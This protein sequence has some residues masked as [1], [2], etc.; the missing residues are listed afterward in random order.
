VSG[1]RKLLAALL[2]LTILAASAAGITWHKKN[3]CIVDHKVYPRNEAVL[4]LRSEEISVAHYEKLR[5]ELPKCEI[6]WNIPFQGGIYSPET[7]KLQ[8]TDISGEELE[9]LRYFPNLKTIDARGCDDLAVIGRLRGALPET[10]LLYSVEVGGREYDQSAETVFVN[11]ITE[12]EIDSLAYLPQ[13]RQ[14]HITGGEDPQQLK[15]LV[16]FCR[17]KDVSVQVKLGGR[18]YEDT[19]RNLAISNITPE[20]MVLLHC[21]P[22]LETVSLTEPQAEAQ[23]LFALIDA[24]PEVKISWKK[25]VLGTLY[26]GD[27]EQI[28]LTEAISKEG[29]AICA[30]AR[31]API[32]GDRDE[33]NWLFAIKEKTPLPDKTADTAA[34][35]AEVEAALEYFPNLRK[36]FLCGSILDNEAMA[37]FRERHRDGYLPVW[38]VQCGKM[39]VRTDTPYFMPTKYHVYYFRDQD[40]ENLR[41]CEDIICVDLGHMAIQRIDWVSYMPKLRYLVLA[42]TD[43]RSIEPI[44]SCKNLKFLELDWSAVPDYSPLKGC[45]ALEDLNLGNTNRDFTPIEEMTWLKNLW[46]VGCNSGAAYRLTQALPDTKIVASGSATV[47]GG[48]RELPNYKAMRDTMNMFYMKW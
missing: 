6:L 7:Q 48:W 47:A 25:E 46:M 27:T 3:Y 15:R 12:E 44:S 42:H 41:Y 13:L 17:E 34:L 26:S 45:T 4:D 31:K 1:K 28:D 11:G 39:A 14:V 30:N 19:V 36:V 38:T 24:C 22:E 2:I 37:A 29:A 33:E 23:S 18:Y 5:A 43:V 20:Q 8:V 21:F 35:I 9:M 16:A 10:E 32:L 40:G